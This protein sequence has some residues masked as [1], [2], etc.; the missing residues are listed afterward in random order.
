HP[1]RGSAVRVDNS[2]NVTFRNVKVEWT[3][4]LSMSN[5]GYAV[6]PVGSTNVLVENCEVHGAS[7]AGI[8]VGQ[9]KNIMVRGNTVSMNVNGI[10]IENSAG[11]EVMNNMVTDNTGGILIF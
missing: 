3:H 11:A 9:S 5:G 6:Y 10:E 2:T 1:T 4:G 8:Y 7:D